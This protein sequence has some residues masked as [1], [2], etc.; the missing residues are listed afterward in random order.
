MNFYD[1]V[2]AHAA[3][4]ETP[5]EYLPW[6]PICAISAVIKNNVYVEK[7]VY[8]VFPNL[9]VLVT[10]VS[11]MIK[12]YP[13]M[14]AKSLAA[15]TNNT[16]LISGRFSIQA[17]IKEMS[18]AVTR[19]GQAIQTDACAAIFSGEFS[20]SIVDDPQAM[21]I[22]TDLY[23]TGYNAEWVNSLKGSGKETLKGPCPVIM[24]AINDAHFQEMM[25]AREIRGGFIARCLLIYSD[26][27]GPKNSLLRP[28]ENFDPSIAKFKFHLHEISQLKGPMM[29][30]EDA[31]KEYEDWYYNFDPT[32]I[33]DKTGGINRLKDKILKVAMCYALA[34]GNQRVIEQHHI[35]KAK[36][37]CFESQIR[38][39]K[40]TKGIGISVDSSKYRMVINALIEA[41]GEE[42]SRH[43]LLE[44]FT[45]DIDHIDFERIITTLTQAGSVETRISGTTYFYKF[46][47]EVIDGLERRLGG[48][49]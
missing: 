22:L 48:K 47:S 31:I 29:L 49:I 19:E 42:R 9:Y 5:R 24:G 45:G 13:P 6:I 16:R 15:L 35:V 44:K 38:L 1:G 46:K 33:E 12:S 17:L 32:K 37:L 2:I 30:T 26:K 40:L 8:R 43:Y 39:E 25:T 18:E 27:P 10:G 20:A 4:S 11:G 3:K 34:T 23:D 21:T 28:L 14:L 36:E 7:Q 41:R